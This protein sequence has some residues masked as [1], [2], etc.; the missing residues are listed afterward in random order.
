M[1]KENKWQQSI[2]NMEEM[3]LYPRVQD[4]SKIRCYGCCQEGHLSKDCPNRSRELQPRLVNSNITM[5]LMPCPCCK[6]KYMYTDQN[7]AV[8]GA[9]RFLVCIEWRRKSVNKRAARVQAVQG[10]ACACIGQEPIRKI[11]VMPG[12]RMDSVKNVNFVDRHNAHLHGSNNRFCN[13]TRKKPGM[14]QIKSGPDIKDWEEV[15][16]R[17]TLLP[18]QW[19]DME[20]PGQKKSCL[21]FFYSG[22][23]VTVVRKWLVEEAGLKGYSITCNL[24][25]T[26]GH[27]K[28]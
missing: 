24:M 21:T 13:L 11:C 1:E 8:M 28:V 12:P 5:P 17:K 25:T 16:N 6:K 14:N 9:T 20:I 2:K 15:K 4:R 22:S 27:M 3:D 23:N 19:V 7:G 10:C 18:V 26:G